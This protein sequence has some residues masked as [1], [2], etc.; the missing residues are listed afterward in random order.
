MLV[1]KA[2]QNTGD[3]G[4]Q[5][6][7]LLHLG[8][9]QIQITIAQPDFFRYVL[10]VQLERNRIGSVEYLQFFAQNL[11]LAGWQSGVHG[12]VRAQPH[13]AFNA[14]HEFVADPFGLREGIRRVGINHDL[15]GTV[16]VA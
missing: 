4:A 7:P 5:H 9:T 8:A 16:T 12:A 3:P 14:Q 13:A 11:D 10:I 15:Y 2:P 1:Q 6:Q